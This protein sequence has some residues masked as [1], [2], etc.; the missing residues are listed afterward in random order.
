MV[1]QRSASLVLEASTLR[2]L[3]DFISGG[4]VPPTRTTASA[5]DDA[6]PGDLL[7]PVPLCV[8]REYRERVEAGMVIVSSGA[9]ASI[10]RSAFSCWKDS[11]DGD[12]HVDGDEAF[13]DYTPRRWSH[14]GG[15]PSE[16]AYPANLTRREVIV[17]TTV[18]KLDVRNVPAEAERLLGWVTDPRKRAILENFRRHSMLEVSGRWPEILSPE[19]TVAHP[20]YRIVDGAHTEIFDGYDAVA[21]FYSGLTEAGLNVLAPIEERMAVSDWGLAIESLLGQI[22]RGDQLP[23]FGEPARDSATYYL[24]TH[25]V[26]NIWPYD[27]DARLK[28]ENVYIDRASRAIY[29]MDESEVTTPAMAAE[30]LAPM[31]DALL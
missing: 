28:G 21:G 20:V 2:A 9:A 29:E 10:A 7:A 23:I 14:H 12:V 16:A 15:S 27:D 25:N 30:I 31:I 19:L 5:T 8:A 13:D 3:R 24:M 11:I 18:P 4:W 6:A 22:L 26:A 1:K 17:L